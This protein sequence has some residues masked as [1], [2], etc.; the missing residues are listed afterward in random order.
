MI[1]ALLV[2]LV[3]WVCFAQAAVN[4]HL[5]LQRPTMNRTHVV[6]VYA[7][8]LWSVPLA[9]GDATRL[10]T[11]AGVETNPM[12]SPDGTQI[13]FTGEYDGNVDA[14]VIPA[15]GGVPKRL[16]WHPAPDLVLGWTPDGK[17]VL[18]SS[19]RQLA[20]PAFTSCT[21][22]GSTADCPR[23]SR[24][25]RAP[26]ARTRRMAKSW[27]TFRSTMPSTP[28]SDTAAAGP[29]PSG[30]RPS[31][32]ATSRSFRATTPTTSIPCGWATRST[33]SPTATARS[34]CSATTSSPSR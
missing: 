25:R 26:R 30:S 21:R 18:F 14:Y 3:C 9:G 31:P 2:G 34:P 32:A 12:F 28:G 17:R 24:C 1:R 19:A 29:R 5:L 33:S 10:T 16:T 23:K 6:F 8:D 15:A 13:A 11:G 7:G 4:E 27:P 22:P 20:T